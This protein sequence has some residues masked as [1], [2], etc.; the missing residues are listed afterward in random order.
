M[1][2]EK[3]LLPNDDPQEWALRLSEE[4]ENIML[5]GHLP[6]LSK[7]A[8]LLLTKSANK[9]SIGFKNSD[10]VCLQRDDSRNWMLSWAVTP[11]IL[12]A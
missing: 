4:K 2:E 5:M 6:N 3:D 11:E 8:S 12:G 7:L 1:I 10:I 9:V